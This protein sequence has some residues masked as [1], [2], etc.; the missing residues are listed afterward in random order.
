MFVY[1]VKSSKLKLVALILVVVAA[2]TA[3]VLLTRGNKPAV[4]SGSIRL[5]AANAAE[6]LAFLS[7]F[8][9]QVSEDPIEVTEVI[10]PAEFDK[11]YQ[12]YNEIQKAQ[13]L[14]LRKYSGKRVKR[15]T[16]E[17]KNYPGY[18]NKSGIVQANLLIYE[19]S[20]IGG[21]ICSLELNGFLHGF[22]FPA[23]LQ[24]STQFSTVP[25]QPTALKQ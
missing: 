6:R 18:E 21:D 10:I 3:L 22:D 13:S 17:V 19:G 20:V 16:Y 25:Q 1:S 15:W 7:Q 8:G 4:K 24:P 23:Y 12:K 14:D 5:S 11:T 2:V 9:W